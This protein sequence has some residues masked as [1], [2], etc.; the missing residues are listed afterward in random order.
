MNHGGK[1]KGAGRKPR[2]FRKQAITVRVEPEIAEL[3]REMCKETQRSQSQQ[4][5]AMVKPTAS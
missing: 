5:A 2:S 4:F 1:R 3:F